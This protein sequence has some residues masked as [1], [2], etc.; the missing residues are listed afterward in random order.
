MAFSTDDTLEVKLANKVTTLPFL[1]KEWRLSFTLL[2][3]DLSDRGSHANILH[4]TTGENDCCYGSRTPTIFFW[5]PDGLLIQS[6]I[7]G[8]KQQ[9]ANFASPTIGYTSIEIIQEID[10]DCKM[11]FRVFINGVEEHQVENTDPRVFENVAVYAGDP[12]HLAH[13]PDYMLGYI[14]DLAI[15]VKNEPEKISHRML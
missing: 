14:Q 6:A 3:V 2:S 4:L 7:S 11:M 10:E 5:P 1:S 12:W 8:E 15:Y 13:D 9:S